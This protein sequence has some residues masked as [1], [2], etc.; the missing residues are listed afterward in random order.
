[1]RLVGCFSI[2]ASHPALPG[3]F[4]GQPLVPGVVLLDHAIA[5]LQPLFPG[6][7]LTGFSEVK[8]AA[9]VLPG[10]ELLVQCGVPSAGRVA[11]ACLRGETTVARG[12][13]L[14]ERPARQRSASAR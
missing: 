5:L 1:M 6:M 12:T 9:A 4:P 2:P 13:I 11:F 14:L 7:A 8:F 3:H 10:E